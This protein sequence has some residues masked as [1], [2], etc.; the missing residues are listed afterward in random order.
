MNS[1][2]DN[3][4]SAIDPSRWED[5]SIYADVIFFTSAIIK[6]IELESNSRYELF[7]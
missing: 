3:I 7:L 6:S 5:W 1:K 2:I 4:C